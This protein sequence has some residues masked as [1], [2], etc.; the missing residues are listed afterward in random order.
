METIESIKKRVESQI[1]S[2]REIYSNDQE[3]L[4]NISHIEQNIDEYVRGL[5]AKESIQ[6]VKDIEYDYSKDNIQRLL[7]ERRVSSG[8]YLRIEPDDQIL[9]IIKNA[10]LDRSES[11]EAIDIIRDRIAQAIYESFGYT[12]KLVS[13]RE[14]KTAEENCRQ[15]YNPETLYAFQMAKH[16]RGID[17][18]NN[19]S[20]S[21]R[22]ATDYQQQFEQ[23]KI[24]EEK[25]EAEKQQFSEMYEQAAKENEEFDRKKEEE[26]KEAERQ[27]AFDRY[28]KLKEEYD[29]K[30]IFGKMF[31]KLTGKTTELETAKNEYFEKYA[32][33]DVNEGRSR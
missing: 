11:W 19:V 2:T 30:S 24:E 29:R 21:F 12:D 28:K 6:L 4:K 15:S 23:L 32:N 3:R 5:I 22:T 14:L 7:K 8:N 10:W 26:K 9:D 17:V 13:E 27:A 25:K 31:A 16:S 1:K 20:N 18:T 33:V